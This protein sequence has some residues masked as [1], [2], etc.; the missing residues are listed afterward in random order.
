[1][2][3]MSR[4]VSSVPFGCTIRT[5]PSCSATNRRPSGEKARSTGFV[6]WSVTSVLEKPGGTTTSAAAG[7]VTLS[8]KVSANSPI[9]EILVVVLWRRMRVGDATE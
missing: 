8:A 3:L 2:F 7:G 4:K 9:T 1:L 6:S 5:R